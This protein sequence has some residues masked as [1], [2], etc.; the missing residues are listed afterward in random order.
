M[1]RPIDTAVVE[2]SIVG[3]TTLLEKVSKDQTITKVELP[4]ETSLAFQEVQEQIQG[5]AG[6]NAILKYEELG[7]LTSLR[8]LHKRS[9]G[10]VG[11]EMVSTFIENDRSSGNGKY[12]STL[13]LAS[14][15]IGRV[16]ARALA[17]ALSSGS[18]RAK[19]VSSVEVYS[20]KKGEYWGSFASDILT[21]SPSITNVDMGGNELGDTG[22][23]LLLSNVSKWLRPSDV[24]LHLDYNGITDLGASALQNALPR[25]KIYLQGNALS[26]QFLRPPV[27]PLRADSDIWTDLK[28]AILNLQATRFSLSSLSVMQSSESAT[29][30]DAMATLTLNVCMRQCRKFIE[31]ITGQWTIAGFIMEDTSTKLCTL[32]SWGMGTKFLNADIANACADVLVKDSHSEVLARRSLKKFFCAYTLAFGAP[33]VSKTTKYHLYT[34]TSP[35]TLSKTHT[36]SCTE[37]IIGWTGEKGLLGNHF[38]SVFGHVPLA[39]LIIGKKYKKKVHDTFSRHC[40]VMPTTVRLE[41]ITKAK[42]TRGDTDESR[43]FY[44]GCSKKACQDGFIHDG[45]TGMCLDG[46]MS[47]LC[48]SV[49]HRELDVVKDRFKHGLHTT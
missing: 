20:N 1:A 42:G 39:S 13:G 33:P 2:N 19:S 21:N 47:E 17:K 44:F 36:G 11:T 18:P 16:G 38:G 26:A 3:Y 46:R 25:T 43:S 37:K 4:K 49:L 14:N 15:N 28:A 48:S 40:T 31:G 7:D 22:V 34:S 41:H 29:F 30:A 27:P 12:I 45:R 32:V 23:Y 9:L 8:S 6:I 24:T 35:C 10:D 5:A